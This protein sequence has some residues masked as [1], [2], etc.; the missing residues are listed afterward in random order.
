MTSR[1]PD[2]LD[3][4]A[5]ATIFP[6][7][8]LYFFSSLALRSRGCRVLRRWIQKCSL[9]SRY[10]SMWIQSDQFQDLYLQIIPSML[11]PAK[12]SG[13]RGRTFLYDKVTH[14]GGCIHDECHGDVHWVSLWD[15]G[16]FHLRIWHGSGCRITNRL[17]YLSCKISWRATKIKNLTHVYISIFCILYYHSHGWL[18]LEKNF[19]NFRKMAAWKVCEQYHN[20]ASFRVWH[21]ILV[22]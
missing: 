4:V 18:H 22:W 21:Q 12:V 14:T 9:V 20:M 11:I 13:H 6:R 19:L 7:F 1:C 17:D 16:R 5:V 3:V 2:W 15:C 8:R 10:A